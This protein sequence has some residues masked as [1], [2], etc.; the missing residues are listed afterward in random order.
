MTNAKREN[1]NLLR[2]SGTAVADARSAMKTRDRGL[3]SPFI[4]ADGM[5]ARLHRRCLQWYNNVR[6]GDLD[7]VIGVSLPPV[8]VNWFELV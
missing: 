4:A 6:W 2:G 7:G 1:G 8:V 3:S 5:R